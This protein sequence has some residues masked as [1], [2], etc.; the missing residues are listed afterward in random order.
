MDGGH[1]VSKSKFLTVHQRTSRLQDLCNSVTPKNQIELGINIFPLLG[2][3]CFVDT[4]KRCNVEIIGCDFEADD[5]IIVIA[6]KLNAYV[7]SN[8]S[9]FFVCD[10]PFVQLNTLNLVEL[11]SESETVKFIPC[12]LFDHKLFQ[13]VSNVL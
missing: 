5:D 7:L 2:K 3:S 9:D 8:D 1:P 6:K 10:V 4:I 13:E 11:Q 12:Y